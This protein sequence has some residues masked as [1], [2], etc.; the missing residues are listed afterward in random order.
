MEADELSP[1][2]KTAVLRFKKALA[3]VLRRIKKEN[4]QNDPKEPEG[5]Q[6]TEKEAA[7]DGQN[8]VHEG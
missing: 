2:A 3:R 8:P 6:K 7:D 5:D 4:T 1:A